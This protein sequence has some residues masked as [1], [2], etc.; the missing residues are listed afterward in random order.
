ML[1]DALDARGLVDESRTARGNAAEL[2]RAKDNLAA[3][4]RLAI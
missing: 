2:L 4:A 3:I 1:A